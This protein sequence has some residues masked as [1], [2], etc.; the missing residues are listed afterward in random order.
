LDS[1]S[2]HY[3]ESSTVYTEIGICHTGFADCPKYVVFYSK[4]KFEKLV[5]LVGFI[6]RTVKSVCEFY[7][8]DN[9]RVC[10]INT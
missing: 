8:I 2:V 10:V 1:V 6:I 5:H 9:V 3:Q 7:V 4:N